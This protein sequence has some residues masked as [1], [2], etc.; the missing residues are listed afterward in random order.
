MISPLVRAKPL[1]TASAWPPSGSLH[2]AVSPA[3][4]RSMISTEPSVDPPSATTYS[5]AGSSWSSTERSASSR[6]R[7]WFSDG[8]TSETVSIGEG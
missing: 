7:A 3:A 2:H 8:V 6:Y 5:S 1:L 4:Y